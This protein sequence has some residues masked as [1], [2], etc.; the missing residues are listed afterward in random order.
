[1]PC[2]AAA[3]VDDAPPRV[4]ALQPQRQLSTLFGVKA[5]TALAQLVDRRRCLLD[6]GLDGRGPAKAAPCRDRIG[7]MAGGGVA[8]LQRCRQ[9]S[10]GPE[11]G[12]L[13]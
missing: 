10:L 9:A 6:Q 2:L 5:D 8:G 3:R 13:R 7:G 11:A 4:A 1:M 12:A